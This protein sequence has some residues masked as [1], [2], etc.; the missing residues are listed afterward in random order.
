M[1][2]LTQLPWE[3]LLE[4]DSFCTDHDL[5]SLCFVC[6]TFMQRLQH[7]VYARGPRAKFVRRI[8][9]EPR[10]WHPVWPE[11]DVVDWKPLPLDDE[12]RPVDTGSPLAYDTSCALMSLHVKF[13]NLESV[14]FAPIPYPRVKSGGQDDDY[15]DNYAKHMLPS[16]RRLDA[17]LWALSQSGAFTRLKVHQL[18]VWPD[19]TTPPYPALSSTNPAWT[20]LA[21]G[22][23]S[24]H[25]ELND[26][27]ED[28]CLTSDLEPCEYLST[29]CSYFLSCIPNV[30]HLRFTGNQWRH[31]LAKDAIPWVRLEIPRLKTLHLEWT[32]FDVGFCM[33]IAK[34]RTHLEEVRLLRCMACSIE[35][36]SLLPT[37]I[38]ALHPPRLVTDEVVHQGDM[39][40]DH[41]YQQ[42]YAT[43]IWTELEWK[44]VEDGD[45]YDE[46]GFTIR[47]WSKVQ[48][49]LE[50]NREL[51]RWEGRFGNRSY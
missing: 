51:R 5:R 2:S 45:S 37:S 20:A 16:I 36:W 1:A 49:L 43:S 40:A 17:S 34:H 44:L 31:L 3:I 41:E 7:T 29:L 33:F 46:D 13:P 48:A 35:D 39:P 9:Y 47:M 28:Y 24:L 21:A 18:P 25:V 26:L 27:L 6:R 23:T 32:P 15:A 50:E 14:S 22:L 11:E 4:I 12:D 8:E 42:F 30:Q 38:V 10:Y 19:S